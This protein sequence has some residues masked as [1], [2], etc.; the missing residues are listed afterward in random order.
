MTD[1]NWTEWGY[2][3]VAAA[4]V[5][6]DA[7]A[8]ACFAINRNNNFQHSSGLCLWLSFK[9][10]SSAGWQQQEVQGK[11]MPFSFFCFRALVATL[12][13]SFSGEN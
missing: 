4:A 6:I 9:D 1:D 3:Q 10:I 8:A 11:G 7:T 5:L 12:S 2:L 13:L